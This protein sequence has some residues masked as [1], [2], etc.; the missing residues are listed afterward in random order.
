MTERPGTNM[1]A[2]AI[3]TTGRDLDIAVDGRGWIA[4][5][6]ADGKE[7]YTRAGDLKI[8]PEGLLQTGAGLSVIGESGKPITIP[9]A[10]KMEIGTD[11]TISIVPQGANATNTVITDRIKLVNPDP[12]SLEKRDDGLMHPTQAGVIPADANVTVVQGALE[13]SNVNALSAM[14]EMIELSKNFEL[15]TKVMKNIDDVAGTASKLMQMA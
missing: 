6:G 8:T 14:V 3:Q 2:G 4:V 11:G 10:Q 5:S 9:P 15:Q 7:A 13:S 1:S 12:A